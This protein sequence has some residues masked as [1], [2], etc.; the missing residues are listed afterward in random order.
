MV[1]QSERLLFANAIVQT[2]RSTLRNSKYGAKLGFD[3]PDAPV[4]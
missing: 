4:E 2:S 1:T 3:T